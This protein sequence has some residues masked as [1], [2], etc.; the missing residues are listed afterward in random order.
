MQANSG[1]SQYWRQK[2][3]IFQ[4]KKPKQSNNKM[5]W[6]VVLSSCYFVYGETFFW[7]LTW[8]INCQ[9][10]LMLSEMLNYT[11]C[12]CRNTGEPNPHHGQA[13]AGSLH[14]LQ[15][16]DRERR[17]GGG[18]QQ[19]DLERNHQG[20]QLTH[21][22][23]Q[24]RLHTSDTV[25]TTDTH[26]CAHTHKRQLQITI[27]VYLCLCFHHTFC[28]TPIFISLHWCA[29]IGAV[30]W[31]DGFIDLIWVRVHRDGGWKCWDVYLIKHLYFPAE[32]AHFSD[33]IIRKLLVFIQSDVAMWLVL[34]LYIM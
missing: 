8:L 34:E 33:L 22:H 17:P 5:M 2:W 14:A 32:M 25:R 31:H 4:T 21:L 30:Y 29:A 12:V 13:G 26:T 15:A 3:D 9:V 28:H 23:H 11:L 7:D 18:H 27:L 6:F 1:T 16:G 24:R 10:M 20:P 19:E